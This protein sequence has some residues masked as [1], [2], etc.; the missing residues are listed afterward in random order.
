VRS[1]RTEKFRSSGVC[2]ASSVRITLSARVGFG[3]VSFWSGNMSSRFP[4]MK[5]RYS[6][7]RTLGIRLVFSPCCFAP[8]RIRPSSGSSCFSF[9][10]AFWTVALCLERADT[11]SPK[12]PMSRVR[13][14][15][16]HALNTFGVSLIDES[17]AINDLSW[18]LI[19]KPR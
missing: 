19:A 13:G 15:S 2:S 10:L 6:R 17:V 12:D 11:K 5:R 1:P 14:F 16:Y 9:G 3:L 4:C 7:D 8:F 18:C